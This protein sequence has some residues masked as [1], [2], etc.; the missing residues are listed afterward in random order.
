MGRSVSSFCRVLTLAGLVVA[1]LAAGTSGAASAVSKLEAEVPFGAYL[2]G[3]HAQQVRDYQA[4]VSWFEDAL[5]A[6]PGSPELITR[7]F[8][9]E[10]SVGRFDRARPLAES[11]LK[12]DS[13]D[14]IADL[15]LHR[16]IGDTLGRAVGVD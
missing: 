4:A 15:V 10:A 7:T 3:R 13:T 12:F 8:L 6:D 9:M 2:A 16:P 14:A 5:K 1:G 11:E